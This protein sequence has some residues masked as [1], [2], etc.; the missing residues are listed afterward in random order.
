MGR[1]EGKKRIGAIILVVLL[2]LALA[3]GA[4]AFFLLRKDDSTDTPAAFTARNVSARVEATYQLQ[5]Q[6]TET[7]LATEDGRTA[8]EFSNSVSNAIDSFVYPQDIVL[9][10]TTS[11]VLF[12]YTFTNTLEDLSVQAKNIK[13][14]LKDKS[15]IQNVDVKYLIS[16]DELVGDLNAKYQAMS[17]ASETTAANTSYVEPSGKIIYFVLVEYTEGTAKYVNNIRWLLEATD[18]NADD[19]QGDP[20][21]QDWVISNNVAIAYNGTSATP[22][23]P[24][25][26]V[27]LSS[28]VFKNNTTITSITIPS[29][30]MSVGANAFENCTS[31]NRVI[32]SDSITELPSGVFK[33]CTSLTD[34]SLPSALEVLPE[35]TFSGCTS[36]E[37]VELP[38][39]ITTI[40]QNAFK[41]SGISTFDMP[42]SLTAIESGA[43]SGCQ[44][45]TSITILPTVTS[46]AA[47]AFEDSGIKEVKMSATSREIIEAVFD[48]QELE[49]IGIIVGDGEF[50]YNSDF[51]HLVIPVIGSTIAD[52]QFGGNL[53]LISAKIPS[54]VTEIGTSAFDGCT[55]LD[56]I[57]FA[58]NSALT[59]IGAKA[60]CGCTSLETI[61]IPKSV[62][63][64]DN[65]AF[66]ACIRLKQVEIEE[67]SALKT[68]GEGAFLGTNLDLLELPNTVKTIGKNILSDYI[69][70]SVI[71]ADEY[72][73]GGQIDSYVKSILKIKF[74]DGELVYYGANEAISNIQGLISSDGTFYDKLAKG[75]LNEIVIPSSV[76]I[77]SRYAFDYC[78]LTKVS[79]AEG[80]QLSEIYRYAFDYCD[81]LVS[82]DLPEGLTKIGIGVFGGCNR[83]KA[84]TFPS[85]LTSID[86]ECF[87]DCYSLETLTLKAGSALKT[88]GRDA[89]SDVSVEKLIIEDIN[90][91][92]NISFYDGYTNPMYRAEEVYVGDELFTELVIPDN[93]TTI[94]N[95]AFYNCQ[96]LISL[97]IPSTVTKIGTE[98][99]Y[100]CRNSK[101]LIVKGNTNI[102]L[103][104]SALAASFTELT[105]DTYS[106][107]STWL[108]KDVY[109]NSY[110][111]LERDETVTELRISS[112][113]TTINSHAY[114]NVDT[115]TSVYI[116]KSVTSIGENA[117]RDCNNLTS[118]VFEDSSRV[119]TIGEGA[120]RN[121]DNLTS[122]DFGSNSQLTT[123][124]DY[125]FGYCTSL[126]SIRLPYN[127]N[128]IYSYAFYGC[129][130]LLQAAAYRTLTKGSSNDGYI[131]KYAYETAYASNNFTGSFY[132]SKDFLLYSYNENTV[133]LKYIGVSDSVEIPREVTKINSGAF[134]GG[135][136]TISFEQGSTL[137][138]LSSEIFTSCPNLDTITI[139][140]CITSIS[141]D[142][143]KNCNNL[144]I[145]N[146]DNISTWLNITWS[147]TTSSTTYTPLN[148]G[149]ALCVGGSLYTDLVVPSGIDSIKNYAFNG[150]SYLKSVTIP[151]GVTTIGNYAFY[152]C[153]MIPSVSFPSTLTSIGSYAFGGCKGLASISLPGGMD[154]LGNGAFA[155]CSALKQVDCSEG[156]SVMGAYA[157][158]RCSSLDTIS[159]PN[160]LTQIGSYAF[161]YCTALRSFTVPSGVMSIGDCAFLSCKSL[162]TFIISNNSSLTDIGAKAFSYEYYNDGFVNIK[163]VVVEDLASWLKISF[164]Q[165]ASYKDYKITAN[166]LN[167]GADLYFGE[168]LATNLVVPG[169][170]SAI[171]EYSFY[172]C[173]SIKS[174]SFSEGVTTIGPYA[175]FDCSFLNKVTIPSTLTTIGS[176][177][178]NLCYA[179]K[180][181]VNYNS[182]LTISKGTTGNGYIA[183]WAVVVSSTPVEYTTD[184]GYNMYT[185]GDD[186]ILVHYSGA[187]TD[188]VIPNEVTIISDYA[189]YKNANI[190]SVSFEEGSQ[191]K[192]IKQYAF[193]NC[194]N[195]KSITIPSG[196]TIIGQYA[197]YSCNALSS[198][199]FD[200]N[201]QLNT[202]DYYAFS[203]CHALKCIVIPSHVSEI[204][205]S[206]FFSRSLVVVIFE[207]GSQLTSIGNNA[208]SLCHELSVFEVPSGVTSIGSYAF[209]E[210]YKLYTIINHSGLVLSKGS[211]D[212]GN[213]AYCAKSI[214]TSSPEIVAENNMKY[215]SA[216]SEAVLFEYTGN[217]SSVTIPKEITSII[218]DVFKDRLNLNTVI[219]EEGSQLKFI[220]KDAF[221]GCVNLSKVVNYSSLIMVAGASGNGRVAYYALEVTHSNPIA[222]TQYTV[223]SYTL[224]AVGREIKLLK[225]NGTDTNLVIPKEIT[226][227]CDKAFLGNESIISVSFEEGS[228][229]LSIGS[230]AFRGCSALREITFPNT[231]KEVGNYAFAECVELSTITFGDNSELSRIAPYAF[232]GCAKLVSI[233]IP[234]KVHT[235]GGFAFFDCYRLVQVINESSFVVNKGTMYGGYTAYYALEVC[236]SVEEKAGIFMEE[237]GFVMFSCGGEIVIIDYNGTDAEIVIPKEATAILPR[238]FQSDTTITSV[239]FESGSHIAEIAD[240]VFYG[241]SGLVSIEIPL[242][243]IS[244]GEYAFYNCSALNSIVFSDVSGW[245]P[246]SYYYGMISRAAVADPQLMAQL[247]GSVLSSNTWSKK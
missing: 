4:V 195:L 197:F 141:Y 221:D 186:I 192:E 245:K 224:Y 74:F 238:A 228:E 218:S 32:I 69:E 106:A 155:S 167:R 85:T 80:S 203:G 11:Y 215:I 51:Q 115:I 65:D 54:S 76:K 128:S 161:S 232:M 140:S 83:L 36:L 7:S 96:S 77:I 8:I 198:V 103:G 81:H 97:T 149:T 16:S 52:N 49:T 84:I 91:W 68:V 202:I 43:F 56:Y 89:L 34:V 33:G 62:K 200:T 241:C 184:N 82:I 234:S 99:F 25:S 148:N 12:T 23:I 236:N 111:V 163:K 216:G 179:L 67:N 79:F 116:P 182:S 207:A 44:D 187:E 138:T 127:V 55:S 201:S 102:N 235:I 189:F 193:S 60:F 230:E 86:V 143:F 120:F 53:M 176:Y 151:E 178:F 59:T 153:A 118:V 3:G 75:S 206:A 246:S 72:G 144:S 42:S 70:E 73:Y 247:F 190:T 95:Y 1:E 31:L 217:E 26:V 227:I 145:I 94:K 61:S 104:D 126:Y 130:N 194:T 225:Y 21:A 38:N 124:R 47:D 133:L 92:F 231:I 87:R 243:V 108:D 214:I 185:S 35:E 17:T 19:S 135:I 129:S 27:S 50:I 154:S 123:I 233:T 212:Y 240:N 156:L 191:L 166:P 105:V 22:T 119:T 168:E 112:G 9:N 177:A 219:F 48:D 208:F 142:A 181:V 222:G 213:I 171:N 29:T 101:Y 93:I 146:V 78:P 244:I 199:T 71:N 18:K 237:N 57:T 157:F 180:T 132:T 88:I 162:D 147:G 117:F 15:I 188:L 121:C 211:T 220:E 172:G 210:C 169:D 24:S 165:S 159:L 113:T 150:Y 6:A 14:T 175:F 242:T 45:L 158:S 40:S 125:A 20:S 196:V 46:I 205:D 100:Y 131:A 28:G 30:V 39:T 10:E 160:S 13:I 5:W 136:K 183:N 137:T 152:N 2:L 58:N 90:D 223:D 37:E 64:I 98:A 239:S 41:D 204:K 173:S 134:N 209:S 107:L 110:H 139:P 114:Y 63:T 174:V 109:V 170:I 164:G 229:L 226:C 66:S 122:V